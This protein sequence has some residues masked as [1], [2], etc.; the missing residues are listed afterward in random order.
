MGRVYA[1]RQSALGRIVALKA[2]PDTGSAA[3]AELRFLR[4]AQTAARLRHPHIVGVHDSGRADGHVFFTMDYVEGGDLAQRLRRGPISPRAAAT[5]LHQIAQALAYTHREGVL[6]RDLKPSN[7]LLDGD[8]PRLADFGLAAELEPGGDLTAVTGVLGTPHYLA[9]EAIRGGS[10]ALTAA[11]DLYAL[12]VITYEMLT[13]RTPF[14]GAS[15][16]ELPQ[17]VEKAAPPRLRYLAP[18]TPPDLETIC[19][20]LLEREPERRY[21]DAA[22]LAEDLRRFLAGEAI[23]A[24]PPGVWTRLTR[25]ARRHRVAFGIIAAFITVL[26]AATVISSSLAIRARH[27][28]QRARA[29]AR[30]SKALADFLQNDLLA[31]ASPAAQADRDLK[32]R[33][34]LDRA[35]SRLDGRFE[36]DPALKADIYRVIGQVYDSLGLYEQEGP[37][38]E[39][40][41]QLRLREFGAEDPR[42]LSAA[43][44]Y[45]GALE[46]L[47]RYDEAGH[48]FESTLRAQRRVLGAAHPD[49]LATAD[50]YAANL[51]DRGKLVEAEALQVETLAHSRRVHG[52]H[53]EAL[54]LGLANLGSIYMA[55][56]RY[57]DAEVLF[58]EAAEI[59][60]TAKGADHPDTL[61][62]WNNVAFA[63]RD[64]GKFDEAAAINERILPLRRK[65]LGPEHH[66]TLVTINN[67]GGAYKALG[68]LAEAESLQR[69]GVDIARRT[70]GDRHME[71][72]VFMGNLADTYRRE[73]KLAEAVA[74]TRQTLQLRRAALGT[75][76]PH[77]LGTMFQLGDL[78]LRQDKPA[79]AEPILRESLTAQIQADA[80]SW[81]TAAA[82]AQLGT[83]LAR[84]QQFSA[85]EPLLLEGL[86]SLTINLERIPAMR[87]TI[88][89]ETRE[90]LAELY[91]AW[92]KPERAAEFK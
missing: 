33:T 91:T 77:T 65:V 8:E 90:H 43:T 62:A 79:E 1:A 54:S 69:T 37:H 5:M 22:A 45:A 64:Q 23:L 83:A 34:V 29:E 15:A 84:T 7:I 31:Q 27:A 80:A 53:A 35:A 66:D 26:L 28:E 71:T 14:A 89:T 48:L 4:E 55:K 88:V 73:N 51:R 81:M 50:A 59:E 32:L 40:S 46:N 58:R 41:W 70:L 57:T 25:Y 42:T 38:L 13:G 78:L 72:L 24:Q 92:G 56:S 63:C 86:H 21:A 20:K 19:L 85:A 16:V 11:S 17:L 60:S 18:A 9:P 30:T 47:A 39:R 49:T 12:G 68:R 76:H 3:V 67:L 10:A 87:R 75:A 52:Q 44:D 2:I 6:H 36:S 74:L 61:T 82:R